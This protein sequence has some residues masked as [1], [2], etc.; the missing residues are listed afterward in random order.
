MRPV[1]ESLA[2][3]AAFAAVLPLW[4]FGLPW[5]PYEAGKIAAAVAV[6]IG[7]WFGAGV[8]GAYPDL[9]SAVVWGA[10]V[11]VVPEAVFLAWWAAQP[12]TW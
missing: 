3:V 5:G 11:F 2:A 8:W 1:I 10:G 6:L 4:F 9:K 12:Y 7:L